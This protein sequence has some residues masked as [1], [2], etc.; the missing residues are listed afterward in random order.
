MDSQRCSRS[1]SGE[2][3]HLLRGPC[4]DQICAS[5]SASVE[6]GVAT[7]ATESS[8]EGADPRC[9]VAKGVAKGV[10]IGGLRA[11]GTRVERFDR[12]PIEPFE[13]FTSEFGQNSCQNSGKILTFLQ[14]ILKF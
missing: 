14:K 1:W 12:R 5:D 9:G 3:I 2:L 10:A 7:Q 11:A 6:T 4:A 8:K 13:L